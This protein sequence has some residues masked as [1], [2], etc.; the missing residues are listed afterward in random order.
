MTTHPAAGTP[1][2]LPGPPIHATSHPGTSHPGVSATAAGASDP[3]DAVDPAGQL[4]EAL[5]LELGT[6]TDLAAAIT[7]LTC[8]HEALNLRLTDT[9]H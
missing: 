4:Q 2:P 9:P 6:V 5:A 8:A 1:R 7:T 3:P